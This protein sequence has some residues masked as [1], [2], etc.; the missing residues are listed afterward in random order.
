MHWQT[1]VHYGHLI[2]S[3]LDLPITKLLPAPCN[4]IFI[5]VHTDHSYYL[6]ASEEINSDVSLAIFLMRSSPIFPFLHPPFFFVYIAG[7]YCYF[8]YLARCENHPFEPICLPNKVGIDVVYVWLYIELKV[9]FYFVSLQIGLDETQPLVNFALCCI[10][11]NVPKM[12]QI[13][14]KIFQLYV[15]RDTG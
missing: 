10:R 13:E 12:A 8:F 4:I 6:A 1:I 7:H 14:Y 2:G 5:F 15:L 9:L 3:V 11:P